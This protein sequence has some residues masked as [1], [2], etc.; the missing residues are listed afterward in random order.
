MKYV[1]NLEVPNAD[2]N[3]SVSVHN[4]TTPSFYKYAHSHLSDTQNIRLMTDVNRKYKPL[5]RMGKKAVTY[6]KKPKTMSMNH[7][8]S[9]IVDD[10]HDKVNTKHNSV[11]T[12]ITTSL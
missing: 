11:V 5:E 10:L 12:K 1:I 2:D 8:T 3:N 9:T 6:R 4:P 7:I